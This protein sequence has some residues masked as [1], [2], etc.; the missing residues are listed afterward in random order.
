M[1]TGPYIS[2]YLKYAQICLVAWLLSFLLN[3]LT[4]ETRPNIIV[5][6]CDDLGYGDLACYG[7]PH[8]KTPNLD[9]MAADG[10]RFT[11]FYSAAPVCS[12]SRVGL[13]TGR[14]PNRAGVF[15]WIPEG[16]RPTPDARDHVHMRESEITIP[17]L[18]Q[19][20]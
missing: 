3:S 14:S 4:A 20:G 13:M 10:I 18:L 9:Q 6:L 1:K 8:I 19:I 11:D 15:D 12:P 16:N 7:H 5:I 2:R 17:K